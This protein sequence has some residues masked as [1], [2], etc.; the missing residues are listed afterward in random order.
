MKS[1]INKLLSWKIILAALIGL[2][3]FGY[4][5]GG[6]S[7]Y[8]HIGSARL[9]APTVDVRTEI[10]GRLADMYFDVGSRF[11]QGEELF[12]L[13]AEAEKEKQKE[14][15][16]NLESLQEMLVYRLAAVE[17]AMQSYL[18]ARSEVDLGLA[19]TESVNDPLNDLQEEQKQAKAC[20]Q[21]I[22]SSGARLEEL[23][24]QIHQKSVA[25]PC[26]GVI[27]KRQKCQGDMVQAGDIVYSICDPS[28]IWVE[29]VVPEKDISKVAVGQKA[30]ITLPTDPSRQWEGG[31]SW[32]SPIALASGEGVAIRIALEESDPQLRPNLS[33]NVKIKIR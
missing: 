30:L 1:A 9:S 3:L 8:L 28:R 6:T 19:P 17:E 26:S 27:V 29:A 22:A 15:Q 25:A 18:T 10:A 31:V 14:L 2:A 24:R 33:A 16:D 5:L 12:S 11:Q 23:E 21:E 7:P 4:W 13:S 20:Q 32:I